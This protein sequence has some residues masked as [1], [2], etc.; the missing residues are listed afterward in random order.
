MKTALLDDDTI[1]HYVIIPDANDPA[2][3]TTVFTDGSYV[4]D[5]APSE[6]VAA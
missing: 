1:T 2:H 4:R 6:S 5:W 3:F